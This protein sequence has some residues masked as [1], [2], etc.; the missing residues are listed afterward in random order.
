MSS[1]PARICRALFENP[2]SIPSSYRKVETFRNLSLS[3]FH[4]RIYCCVWGLELQRS[5]LANHCN[6]NCYTTTRKIVIRFKSKS[7]RLVQ[8]TEWFS[9]SV[10]KRKK[11]ALFS[12]EILHDLGIASSFTSSSLYSILEQ[13]WR[14]GL[15]KWPQGLLFGIMLC[16]LLEFISL[17]LIMKFTLTELSNYWYFICFQETGLLTMSLCPLILSMWIQTSK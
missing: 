9:I 17:S 1:G 16:H 14:T 15:W 4:T 11:T 5:T 12:I 8:Y 10:L 7:H 2:S 6:S 3:S 13:Y